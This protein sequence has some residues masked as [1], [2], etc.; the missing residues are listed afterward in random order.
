MKP[1]IN[2][3]CEIIKGADVLVDLTGVGEDAAFSEIGIDSLEVFN[4]LLG[5]EEKYG[6]KIPEDDTDSI[7]SIGDIIRFVDENT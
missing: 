7:N 5:V 4:I 6:V 2:D 3:V 1:T